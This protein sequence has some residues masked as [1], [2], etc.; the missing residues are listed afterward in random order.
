MYCIIVNLRL[1]ST[2]EETKWVTTDS[3]ERSYLM[4]CDR[5]LA[6][7]QNVRGSIISG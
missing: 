6:V 3:F 2:R 4:Y 1:N 5:V 7:L